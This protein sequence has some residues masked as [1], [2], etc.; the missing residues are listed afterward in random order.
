M[1]GENGTTGIAHGGTE[2]VDVDGYLARIGAVRPRRADADALA[3]LQL[4]QLRTVPFEN[5]SVHLREE[6]VLDPVALVDKLVRRRRGG[7]CYELNGAFAALL[8]ALG[9]RV[10]LLEARVL[11]A[12]G[13]SAG[14]PYDHLTLSVLPVDGSGPWL[15]DVGFGAFCERPLLLTSRVEQRDAAGVFRI[16]EAPYGDLEVFQDGEPQ[17]RMSLRPRELAEFTAA[18]WYHRTSPDS[19]FTRKPVC[20]LP[21]GDGRTTLSGRT[22]K[23]TVTGRPE[24]TCETELPDEAAVL[25]AY[26]RYFGIELDREPVPFRA[27]QGVSRSSHPA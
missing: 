17:F 3:E 5:L 21:T 10:R 14:L 12:G 15:V 24:L 7:F 2:A 16:V 22:L 6:I 11:E 20:S 18:C 19:H 1:V 27:A 9:F 13:G 23:R 4:R 8:T 25:D 26:R